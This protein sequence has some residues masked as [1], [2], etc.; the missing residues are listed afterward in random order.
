[1][2][3]VYKNRIHI[4]LNDLEKRQ[5]PPK[6]WE[7]D[8][9]GNSILKTKDLKEMCLGDFTKKISEFQEDIYEDSS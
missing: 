5:E 1:M 4:Y 8:L 2:H 9:P 7:N 3:E 6:I